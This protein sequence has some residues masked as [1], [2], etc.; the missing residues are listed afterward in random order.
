[1]CAL[2]GSFMSYENIISDLS[3]HFEPGILYGILGPNGSGKTTLLRL[4]SRIYIPKNGELH[5]NGDNISEYSRM[6]LSRI[7]SLVPQQPQ[8]NFDFTVHDLVSMGRYVH[9]DQ[10]KYQVQEALELVG[11][12][13]LAN[14]LCSTLSS[15]ERQLAYIARSIAS[16]T[17]VIL[18][19]EPTAN[20]DVHHQIVIWS[21]LRKLVEKGKVVIVTVH[22]LNAAK[23][24]ADYLYLINRGKLVSAGKSSEVLCGENLRTVFKISCLEP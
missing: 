5:W 15:G 22:D 17:P 6:E 8:L 10:S 12:K 11:I 24:Y 3:V 16:D 19:D 13:N 2:T 4:L 1:M 20:L 14:Q 18:L 9:S 21:L 7:V 23:R